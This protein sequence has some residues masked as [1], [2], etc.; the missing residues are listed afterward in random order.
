MLRLFIGVIAPSLRIR[1]NFMAIDEKRRQ[2]KLARKAAKRKKALA[3]R[4]P[5]Y[6]GGGGLFSGKNDGH[7]GRIADP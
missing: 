1:E 5:D 6:S 2:K 7:G 4:K 3:A